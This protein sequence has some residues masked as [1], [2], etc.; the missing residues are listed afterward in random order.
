[1]RDIRREEGGSPQVLASLLRWP[2]MEERCGCRKA[3]SWLRTMRC[4]KRSTKVEIVS[5]RQCLW[6]SRKAESYTRSGNAGSM[7]TSPGLIFIYFLVILTG[8]AYEQ[9]HWNLGWPDVIL[10]AAFTVANFL[11]AHAATRAQLRRQL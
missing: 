2:A 4:T 11:I 6:L 8:T 1:M 9:E 10:A 5:Q 3:C 7:P